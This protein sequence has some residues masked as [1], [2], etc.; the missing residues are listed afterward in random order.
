MD[1]REREKG[2]GRDSRA[3]APH[4]KAVHEPRDGD[5][6]R[7]TDHRRE[8]G[9]EGQEP[10]NGPAAGQGAPGVCL[11]PQPGEDGVVVDDSEDGEDEG[12][13]AKGQEDDLL[14]RGHFLPQAVRAAV[15]LGEG[16][17]GALDVALA[18]AAAVEGGAA[19]VRRVVG[20]GGGVPL[21]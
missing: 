16:A 11:G 3:D 19:G 12:G 2:V 10:E 18:A 1:W 4:W 15:E 9:Q 6:G 13:E 5:A 21:P 8:G 20:E 7:I 17:D 14:R